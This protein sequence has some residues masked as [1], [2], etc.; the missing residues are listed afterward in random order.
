M[1]F[2][3]MERSWWRLG[4]GGGQTCQ[5]GKLKLGRLEAASR[6]SLPD[7]STLHVTRDAGRVGQ[8]EREDEQRGIS[9]TLLFN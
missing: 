4:R 3:L 7:F 1:S 9:Y 6:N 8:E 2:G 5:Q